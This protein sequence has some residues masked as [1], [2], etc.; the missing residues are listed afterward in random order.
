[1]WR[2]P[3]GARLRFAHLEHDSDADAYQGHSYSR[4][5]VEEKLPAEAVADRIR[6]LEAA[7]GKIAYGVL[8]PATFA[9]DALQPI[10]ADN[11]SLHRHNN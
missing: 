2:F 1:M 4:V 7:D 3:N 6:E 9:S 11:R 10:R 5:Y 8:D